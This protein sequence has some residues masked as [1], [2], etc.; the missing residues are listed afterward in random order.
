MPSDAELAALILAEEN[1]YRFPAFT[2]SDAV[3]L[4]L[5]LRKRFRGSSRHVKHGRGLIISIQTIG[6]HP[7]FSCTVGDLAAGDVSLDN[8]DCLEGMIKVVRRT[9]HS[10]YYAEKGL[11]SMSKGQLHREVDIAPEYHVKGGGM[12]A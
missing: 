12:G 3:T 9:G 8:W 1:N 4:G 10:S 11:S 6:G 7:L 2:A 5:S